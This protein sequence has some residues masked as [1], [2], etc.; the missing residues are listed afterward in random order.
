MKNS[1]E[2]DS[3]LDEHE[4]SALLGYYKTLPQT[5]NSGDDKKA[6]TTGFPWDD[7][8]FETIK[9]KLKKVFPDSNVTVSM[10]LEEFIP[11]KVHT[12]YFKEDKVPHYAVLV[13]LDFEDKSTHTVVFNEVGID[14][15][16]RGQLTQKSL[17]QYTEDQTKI[18]N[19]IEQDMLDRLSVGQIHKWEKG[20]MIAWHRNFLHSSDNFENAGIKRKIA[21]VLFLNQDD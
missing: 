17:Y 9:T 3:F 12:D 13:P 10:F 21:L 19:H 11:W 18:L 14:K 2:I 7:L 15:D 6:F 1:F 8:P 20:K 4:L 5:I 16:W